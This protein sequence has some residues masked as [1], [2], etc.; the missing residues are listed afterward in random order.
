MAIAQGISLSADDNRKPESKPERKDEDGDPMDEDSEDDGSRNDDGDEPMDEKTD[1]V[2]KINGDAK[3]AFKE[4]PRE[5]VKESM[6]TTEEPKVLTI[7]SNF[8]SISKMY[9]CNFSFSTINF[10]IS[11]SLCASS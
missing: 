11:L 1:F 6:V 2:H 5:S 9:S 3:V 10:S 8:C 7:L 4:I